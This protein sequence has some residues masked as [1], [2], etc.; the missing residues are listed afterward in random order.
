MRLVPRLLAALLVGTALVAGGATPAVA[1]HSDPKTQLAPLLP[2]ALS[3][4]PLASNGQ[5]QLIASF[6]GNPGTDLE[7]FTRGGST[8][9]STGTFVG[10]RRGFVGQRLFRLTDPDGTVKPTWIADHGSAACDTVTSSATGLQHD[11]QITPA[12]DPQLAIDATDATG[13]CHDPNG[14]GLELIDISGVT[15][16]ATAGVREVH[17]VRLDGTSHNA[18][19][20]ATRPWLVYNSNSDLDRPWIDVLDI[21]SCLDLATDLAGKRAACRPTAYRMPFEP[22]WTS[23]RDAMTNELKN[24]YGCHDIT[25]R[26]GRL[27]CAAVHG[28]VVL[29]VSNL[30][31]ATGA[32]RGTP[33]PCT[34]MAG[35]ST[36]AKVT[37]CDLG[38]G[39]DGAG[40]DDAKAWRDA[41]SPAATGWRA[42]GHV[43]HAGINYIGPR[44]SNNQVVIPASEG[45]AVSHEAD[46]TPDGRWMFVTDERGG[47]LVPP[48]ASC[49]TGA[50]NPVGNGGIH[51]FDLANPS[52]VDYAKTKDGKKA[53]YLTANVVPH[54]TFC[55]V[56]L[57]KQAPGEKR[58]F[59]AWYGQGVKVIDYDVDAAGRWS[60]TEVGWYVLPGAATWAAE[61]FKIMD[62]ADG[63]RTYTLLLSDI[64][65]GVD[66]LSYT[67]K[68]NP[69]A[70][71]SS[72][73]ASGAVVAGVQ[74]ERPAPASGP[75]PATGG[76]ILP[77]ELIIGLA[78][79][80]VAARRWAAASARRVER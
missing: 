14:G 13:R 62:N 10:G 45:I 3:T 40:A 53:V 55:S 31:D 54:A 28:T 37:N 78:V 44:A 42:I 18:T 72:G 67:A 63:T 76:P 47:G 19:V 7:L 79:I 46:P 77:A 48:G 11:V 65:R 59:V 22:S 41:G 23:Q 32:V 24:P 4:T 33:L 2:A 52:K 34:V 73:G 27:Y 61:P 70:S 30:T 80:G 69:L 49:A 9:A 58:L 8:F 6:A 68:P 43:N 71:A 60:F 50:Q 1:D 12:H 5:W 16:A 25:A 35:T 39:N 21:R 15:P 74:T 20:D 75:L 56:H 17:L 51:V 36:S 57:I 38:A 26:P 66:V 64:G 29:D